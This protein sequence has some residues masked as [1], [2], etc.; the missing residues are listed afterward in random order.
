Q[1][2]VLF[3]AT[4]PIV[5][6]GIEDIVSRPDLGDRAIILTLEPIPAEKR[7]PEKVLWAELEAVLPKILGALLDGVVRGL[8][9][10]SS[11]PNAVLPRMAD[12]AHWIAACEGA[13]W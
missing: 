2:E 11:T 4:R 7:K 12:F 13:F 9:N 1:D 3:T 8:R 6:N 10:L 5:L